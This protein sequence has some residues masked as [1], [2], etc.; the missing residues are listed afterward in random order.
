MGDDPKS[1]EEQSRRLENVYEQLA[2]L[3]REPDVMQEMHV[4]RVPGEWSAMNAMGH[5][6]EMIPYWLANIHAVLEAVGES[7]K[8]GRSLDSPERLEGAA[9]G[10]DGYPDK[11]LEQ[12][13]EQVHSAVSTFRGMSP[14]Q[15]EKRGMHITRGEMTVA[16]MI[17]VFVVA[18]S[19]EH[20]EQI[21]TAVN[22]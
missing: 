4:V 13:R 18:H 8:I 3:M 7:P 15:R 9:H 21:R 5:L 19:E 10:E 12:L 17:E 6:V 1:A 22:P 14:A 16:E 11:E 20:L 2:A